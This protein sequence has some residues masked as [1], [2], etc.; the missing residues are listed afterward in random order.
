LRKELGD[1]DFNTNYNEMKNTYLKMAN[2]EL[3]K[4]EN[5]EMLR[6][7]EPNGDVMTCFSN[8]PLSNSL[9]IVL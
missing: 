3:V 1:A 2:F 7:S 5:F 9:N 4:R 8:I 6:L